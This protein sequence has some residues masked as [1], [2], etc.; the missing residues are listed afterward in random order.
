MVTCTFFISSTSSARHFSVFNETWDSLC[1]KLPFE[2]SRWCVILCVKVVSVTESSAAS[3]SASDRV[4]IGRAAYL[5][6]EVRLQQLEDNH[7][8]ALPHLLS[9]F[10]FNITWEAVS[11]PLPQPA[12]TRSSCSVA[13]CSFAGDCLADD[14]L[15]WM[16]LANLPS[17]PLSSTFLR[18]FR[19]VENVRLKN[20]CHKAEL[21]LSYSKFL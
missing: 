1:M 5:L 8:R 2:S 3:A 16:I 7:L 10:G 20:L 9:V 4:V 21:F 11:A 18:E 13:A 15:R 14:H 12:P 17:L 6:V 19:I